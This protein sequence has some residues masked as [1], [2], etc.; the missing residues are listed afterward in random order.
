MKYRIDSKDFFA[1][2][3][4]N[5]TMS[6]IV[7]ATNRILF[8]NRTGRR[9]LERCDEWVDLPEFVSGLGIT[10]APYETVYGDF[11]KLLLELE[12]YGLAKLRDR[13]NR[14]GDGC[15]TADL[16]DGKLV[17]DFLLANADKG[18]SCAVSVSPGYNGIAGVFT[19]IQSESERYL[20]C[21]QGG[22]VRALLA[23][24]NP[25]RS[26]GRSA[27]A[28]NSAVFAE[29]LTRKECRALLSELLAYA[30]AVYGEHCSK[31]RYVY[32]NARQDGLRELLCGLGF[33]QTALLEKEVGG[34]RDMILYDKFL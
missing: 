20:L 32:M 6:L 8:F 24:A 11:E 29:G 19:R 4:E 33:K 30:E 10:A 17:S 16:R 5:G 12:S 18:N 14:A 34:G 26:M 9:L 3:E 23:V 7:R 27:A 21:E 13:E 2:E 1:R 28:I 25:S 31:L 15:R 22:R